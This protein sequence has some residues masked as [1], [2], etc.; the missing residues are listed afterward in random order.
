M[1]LNHVSSSLSMF[2]SQFSQF[3]LIPGGF[4]LSRS[5]R[6]FFQIILEPYYFS[7][8]MKQRGKTIFWSPSPF[9]KNKNLETAEFLAW[10]QKKTTTKKQKLSTCFEAKWHFCCFPYFSDLSWSF[11]HFPFHYYSLPLPLHFLVHY[12]SFPIPLRSTPTPMLYYNTS[13]NGC[14]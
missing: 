1:I 7:R 12:Y 3:Y 13:M 5:C 14:L 8:V 4:F 10:K 9:K 11:S 6:L 2:F